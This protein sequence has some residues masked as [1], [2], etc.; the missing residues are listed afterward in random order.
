MIG[1]VTVGVIS[2]SLITK[3]AAVRQQKEEQAA[4]RATE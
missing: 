4:A 1:I 3:R 2:A